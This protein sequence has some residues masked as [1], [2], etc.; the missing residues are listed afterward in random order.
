MLPLPSKLLLGLAAAAGV[1]AIGFGI[2]VSENDGVTLLAALMLGALVA[3]LALPGAG[4]A[5]ADPVAF[6][7]P[8]ME[9]YS[10]PPAVSYYAP[11]AAYTPAP[12][13]SYYAPAVSSY[14]PAVS[15]YTP[16]GSYYAP[17]ASYYAGP[18]TVTG[19]RTSRRRGGT[20]GAVSVL[21]YS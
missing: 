7:P 21:P 1:F 11:P 17:T 12:Q 2:S 14:P 8:G 5:T 18:A 6:Y 9:C 16:A 19:T 13:V 4:R 15:S 20:T 10:P 3:G